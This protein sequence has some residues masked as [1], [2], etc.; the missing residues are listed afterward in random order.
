M[1]E[2]L[3]KLM[4]RLKEVFFPRGLVCIRCG[5]ELDD[6]SRELELCPDCLEDMPL[7]LD[8]GDGEVVTG[9]HFDK[10]YYNVRYKDFARTMV[11]D[12]KASGK[13]WLYYNMV[14]LMRFP[15][16]N[17]DIVTYVPCHKKAVRKRGFDHAKQ[18]AEY[19]AEKINLPCITTLERTQQLK[20]TSKLSKAERIEGIK[21][22]FAVPQ[23]LDKDTLKDKTVLLVD[24]ILT[25]GATANECARV[26]KENGAKT[27]L[28]AVFART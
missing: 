23:T 11:L 2:R 10:V 24:D 19:Y 5:K 7:C 21:N 3:M 26:L 15:D 14:Q 22:N 12:Y 1:K 13:N 9:V 17:V 16:E 4:S 6:K 20:D 18:L 28:V 27:V 25:T 8:V